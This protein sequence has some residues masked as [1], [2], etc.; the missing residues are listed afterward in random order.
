MRT[1]VDYLSLI[2]RGFYHRGKPDLCIQALIGIAN[3]CR[4]PEGYPVAFFRKTAVLTTDDVK[5]P[6]RGSV[7]HDGV[8]RLR[9]LQPI[10]YLLVLFAWSCHGPALR[11]D[12][13]TSTDLPLHALAVEEMPESWRPFGAVQESLSRTPWTVSESKEAARAAR[14]GLAELIA[15]FEANPKSVYELRLD[16]VEC[17]IDAMYSASNMPEMM[18]R[19]HEHALRN[20][21]LLV[22]H[23]LN[24][25]RGPV[26]C[27]AY[28]WLVAL[29]NYG[30]TLYSENALEK[31]RI[32]NLANA[33]LMSCTE[34]DNYDETLAAGGVSIREIKGLVQW[35]IIMIEAQTVPGLQVPENGT[36]LVPKLW[37][38]FGTY[39]LAYAR[40][41]P[42]GAKNKRFIETA[43]LVTHAGY[44]PTG[45]GR[46]PI[47][48]EDAPWLYRFLRENFYAV[49]EAGNLDLIAEFVDLFRQYGCTEENDLQVRDG[50][51][52]LLRLYREAGESW[53]NYREPAEKG[54]ILHAYALIHKP[55]TGMAG[56]R[57]RVTEPPKEGNYAWVFRTATG[58]S[59]S[60]SE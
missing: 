48:I 8:R 10:T 47:Y 46:H 5:K 59:R 24:R 19:A 33:A 53:I 12:A 16:P 4:G 28:T 25:A 39:P 23:A 31:Q 57:R 58:L 26:G 7:K 38:F 6:V 52:Y 54:K 42:E 18:E 56:V 36:T 40:T 9:T 44:I 34:F 35:S 14:A 60:G 3:R 27:V 20:L 21:T 13:K 29:C 32:I 55:W 22:N 41:Y 17:L 45:Y 49:L 51:R 15:F 30:N 2:R 1:T 11:P 37:E 50:T 43:Y